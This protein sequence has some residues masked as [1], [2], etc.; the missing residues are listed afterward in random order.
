[1]SHSSLMWCD[2][3][4]SA[5]QVCGSVAVVRWLICLSFFN[6]LCC[7]WSLS[8]SVG[9]RTVLTF[10]PLSLCL[11][12]LCRLWKERRGTRSSWTRLMEHCL[13]L[14]SRERLWRTPT[15]TLKFSRTWALLPRPSNLLMKTCKVPLLFDFK[16]FFHSLFG[17]QVAL[18]QDLGSNVHYLQP[19][20]G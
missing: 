8:R 14:S 7:E 16:G 13:P 18:E 10:V 17:N 12:R 6:P 1:M 20:V 2:I 15:P 11:Q 5:L 4:V 3:S 9:F 19:A